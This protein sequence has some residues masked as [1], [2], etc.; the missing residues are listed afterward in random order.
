M[1]L[2]YLLLVA[3]LLVCACNQ[4]P[5][6]YKDPENYILVVDSERFLITADEVR[7]PPAWNGYYFL[8]RGE[9]VFQIIPEKFTT[10]IF[11]KKGSTN[12]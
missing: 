11:M 7:I 5:R 8:L 10:I 6:V 4:S 9:N 1:K 2:F 3:M 12:E